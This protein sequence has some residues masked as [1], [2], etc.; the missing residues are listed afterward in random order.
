MLWFFFKQKSYIPRYW[1]EYNLNVAVQSLSCVWLFATP[2]IASCQAPLL[3][4]ISQFAQIHVY[5]V[6]DAIQ[7]SNPLSLPSPPDLNLSQLQGLF[8]Y[9]DSSH[10]VAKWS[11]CFSISPSNEYSALISFTIDWFDLLAVQRTLKSLL[12]HH[13]S[14][15]SIIQHSAFFMVQLS[16]PYMTTGKTTAL[17]TQTLVSIVMSLL[18]FNTLSKLV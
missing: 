15:A 9:I 1:H 18:I 3:S 14:K 11:F 4:T 16:H 6:S 8:Q 2:W 5:W 7:Q 13:N 17:S 12:Q 10:Q